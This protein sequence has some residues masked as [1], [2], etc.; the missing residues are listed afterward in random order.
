[1]PA[2]NAV[3]GYTWTGGSNF[4]LI[5]G[6]VAL[7]CGYDSMLGVEM[8]NSTSGATVGTG[9]KFILYPSTKNTL[10]TKGPSTMIALNHLTGVSKVAGSVL[11]GTPGN[12]GRSYQYVTYTAGTAP[13][14]TQISASMLSNCKFFMVNDGWTK[15]KNN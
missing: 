3:D 2:I 5:M 13:Y 4:A 9:Q 7:S 14:M 10:A 15:W 6:L 11:N 12:D 8:F 1:L